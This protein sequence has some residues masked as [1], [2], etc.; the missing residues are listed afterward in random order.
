MTYTLFVS[1]TSLFL[2]T[3]TPDKVG[4]IVSK[5]TGLGA[6]TYG[7]DDIY[8]LTSADHPIQSDEIFTY[9][10]VGNRLT[11]TDYTD[12][13][14]NSRNQLTVYNSVTY[15]YDDNG[16]TIS[17]TDT[18]STTTYTY[19]YEN[20]LTRIDFPG[21]GY[22]TYKY[23]VK[24]RRIEKNVDGTVTKYLYDGDVLLAEY[25][26]SDTLQRNYFCGA[27]DINPL[28]LYEGSTM[29]FFHQD[30]LN[31]PQ[32]VTDESGTIVW[33]ATY[34]S[35]GEASVNPSSTITNNFR[36]PGQYYDAE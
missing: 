8:K 10:S 31:T 16:N 14:Y 5:V 19:N 34:K 33:D 12:W 26:G 24:G 22:V 21:G 1:A 23:D 6:T 4:N 2:Q 11:S 30:H 25:N 36:F 32:K 27:S 17:K 7:Y 3:N 29:Y 18:G 20:R 35:F 28:I 9:D 13:D 15:V